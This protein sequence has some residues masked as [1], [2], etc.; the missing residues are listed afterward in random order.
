[1]EEKIVI[2]VCARQELYDTTL[3]IYHDRLR[4]DKAWQ[5]IGKEL[6]IPE[7]TYRQKWKGLR[8][9]Y[10]KERRKES[11]RK[12]WSAAGTGKKWKYSAILS[13]LDPFVNPREAS[14]NMGRG[15][16]DDRTAE[17]SPAGATTEGTEEAA[18]PSHSVPEQHCDDDDEEEE[19]EVVEV[20]EAATPTALEQQPPIGRKRT[21]KTSKG[22]EAEMED[23]LIEALRKQ[24]Q[25]VPQPPG[26]P[27]LEDE[28]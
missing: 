21:R 22:R 26:S 10:L 19:E 5:E 20:E 24:Q 17:Y 13:F 3:H 2:T 12:S 11:E 14:G 9:T 18:G 7:E 28:I 15:V 25:Q 4:N 16:E 8:D 27:V 1:M 23:L 6:G